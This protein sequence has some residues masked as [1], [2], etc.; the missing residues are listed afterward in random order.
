M[1][2]LTHHSPSLHLLPGPPPGHHCA[3]RIVEWVDD[4]R[5]GAGA[6][7]ARPVKRGTSNDERCMVVD[8]VKIG[9]WDRGLWFLG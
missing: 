8:L 6:A 1:A 5:L 2:E 3:D 7:R 9:I 4:L